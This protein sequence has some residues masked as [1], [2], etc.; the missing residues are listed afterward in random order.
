V[1][2]G[3]ARTGDVR[4]IVAD[5]ALARSVLGFQA[6]VGFDEGIRA[7]AGQPMRAPVR[8]TVDVIER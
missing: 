2:V 5:P 1:V 3:G 7:F 4:H 6:A 8:P